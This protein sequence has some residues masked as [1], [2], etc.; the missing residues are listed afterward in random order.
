MKITF[1][2]K[3]RKLNLTL[4]VSLLVLVILGGIFHFWFIN[5]TEKFIENIVA[6]QSNGK[7]QLKVEAVRFNYLNRYIRLK[8]ASF[9]TVDTLDDPNRYY[10]EV[11]D[12]RLK[13]KSFRALL[14]RQEILLDTLNLVK[15]HVTIKH[16][17]NNEA[18]K[19]GTAAT[20]VEFSIAYEMGNIYRSIEDA[21]NILQI[22]YFKINEGRFTLENAL[23]P[24]QPP[25]NIT[26]IYL[27]IDNIAVNRE[28]QR[29][30]RKFLFSDNIIVR[31][32]N[33]QINFP[34]GRHQLSFGAFEMN[35][36]NKRIEIENCR[37]TG[38][39]SD[40]SRAS[41]N[42]FFKKLQL[43][44]FDFTALTNRD[45]IKADSV[46]CQDPE[47]SLSLT[48]RNKNEKNA[49]EPF[50]LDDALRQLGTNMDIG[51]AGLSN[52]D[53]TVTTTRN[54]D[55]VSFNSNG[56]DFYLYGF[57]INNQAA[58]PISLRGID[59]AIRNYDMITRDGS[60]AIKFDSI[61]LR[62]NTIRL[63]NFS[64]HPMQ[65]RRDKSIR[66]ID[67]PL[68]QITGLSWED[69]L[70]NRTIVAS[71]ATLFNPDIMYQKIS[72]ASNS[73]SFFS[74]LAGIDELMEVD[75]LELVNGNLKL[76]LRNKKQFELKNTNFNI[77]SNQF[78]ASQN[79]RNIER[80]IDR[81]NFSD[82][83]I[84]LGN[85][86]ISLEQ[87]SYAGDQKR[88][89]A[90]AV[91]VKDSR[92]NAFA[93][94]RK[95]GISN[96]FVNEDLKIF[97]VDSV[98]WQAGN[99][100]LLTGFNE[101]SARMAGADI[102]IN[103]IFGQ[104]TILNAT[105]PAGQLNTTLND[106]RAD[107]FQLKN[108]SSPV[109]KNLSVQGEQLVA[110]YN[111]T[112]IVAAQY[113]ISDQRQ[114][115]IHNVSVSN[116][117]EGDTM[118]LSIAKIE[119]T[120]S[121]MA[122]LQNRF[123]FDQVHFTAP[124]FYLNK[125]ASNPS[126]S[127]QT[128]M[129]PFRV[130]NLHL[131]KPLININTTHADGA[132]QVYINSAMNGSLPAY[133]R[134]EQIKTDSTSLTTGRI[135]GSLPQVKY[136]YTDRELGVDSGLVNFSIHQSRLNFSSNNWD[137]HLQ[138]ISLRNLIPVNLEDSNVLNVNAAEIQN[139]NIGN[140]QKTLRNLLGSSPDLVIRN[141]TGS[142][143]SLDKINRWYG[144]TYEH[145]RKRITIDSLI[146]S[147]VQNKKTFM[148]AQD[149]Q[150]DYINFTS[151]LVQIEG[152]DLEKI[153]VDS[154]YFAQ[155][156]SLANPSIFIYR[157]KLLPRK[158]TNEKLLP[159]HRIRQVNKPLQ[160]DSLLLYNATVNYSELDK[161][162]KDT[163]SI[164]FSNLDLQMGPIKNHQLTPHDSLYV[165]AQA[166]IFGQGHINLQ[167]QQS[168]M[169]SL[170]GFRM[171][172]Q[173]S[174]P[175]ISLLN[176]T[177][178]PLTTIE[179]TNGRLDSLWMLVNAN[180]EIASGEI[181]LLYDDLKIRL[182]NEDGTEPGFKNN[183]KSFIANTFLI[184]S[185]NN[186]AKPGVIYFER[187]K[188]RSVFNYMV[189]ILLSGISTGIGIRSN[190]SAVKA[191]KDYLKSKPEPS[192]PSR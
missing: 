33:Q 34:G 180:D 72:S 2:P 189:K 31:S 91:V 146:H 117:D 80:S 65:L 81:F 50:Q 104:H 100:N 109:I 149:F 46:Y 26:D 157:N 141:F 45:L 30:A 87:M 24:R 130:N 182:H 51:F 155:K 39:R 60:T 114:S 139:L 48:L 143:Q 120:P 123:Y 171:Q 92:N 13:I 86:D 42:M 14:L 78:M 38:Q 98:H 131:Q 18:T 88:L 64:L 167:M 17:R 54:N 47:L 161:T 175:D 93:T 111:K 105:L 122:M 151:G 137:A 70:L 173:A 145:D 3:N 134:V 127:R 158:N 156:I 168:Y 106:I 37:V 25:V 82:G 172:T 126:K 147:P 28:Q 178:K 121:V 6:T 113:D 16:V 19:S 140:R 89:F 62:N 183:F 57:R 74:A 152:I 125:K 119:L 67:V 132:R 184:R 96:L 164:Q 110:D 191:H 9:I 20:D 95:V 138:N 160:V 79:I 186:A 108:G 107:Q 162:T 83:T 40:T 68:L 129:L 29:H 76:I 5:N 22:K 66:H 174:L 144:A 159:V 75:E 136:I 73:R 23:K 1:I 112:K 97:I 99:I 94:L 84:R 77:R 32:R 115:N 41:F 133:I 166:R 163:G 61:Q 55:P 179:I 15:P 170:A 124:N 101:K 118:L 176:Q 7:V 85:I 35:V 59:V 36:K 142:H 169:D 63:S 153:S 44:N 56:N 150:A 181:Y 103:N 10:F 71:K 53:I 177:I 52:A 90:E 43:L 185:R 188:D 135:N 154:T 128:K 12:L 190:S 148:D 165:H 11:S 116:Y 49:N 4:A 192:P 8:N 58:K 69:L 21:L 27:E 187:L 102:T